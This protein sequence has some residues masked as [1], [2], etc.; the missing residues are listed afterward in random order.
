MNATAG[1]VDSWPSEPVPHR[2]DNVH[3]L[4]GDNVHSLCGTSRHSLP[5][6]ARGD[7]KDIIHPHPVRRTVHEHCTDAQS[8]IVAS[9][10]CERF[11]SAQHSSHNTIQCKDSIQPHAISRWTP[12]NQDCLFGL[13]STGAGGFTLC[14]KFAHLSLD[15]ATIAIAN[16][17]GTAAQANHELVSSRFDVVYFR[18]C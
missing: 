8:D 17:S 4:C 10:G 13:K 3:S 16:V 1:A 2:D 9:H 11:V 15:T 18:H 7:R 5:G 14:A 6:R 12:C